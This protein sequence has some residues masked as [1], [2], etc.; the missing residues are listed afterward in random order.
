M[1][2]TSSACIPGQVPNLGTSSRTAGESRPWIIQRAGP[3][4]WPG[5]GTSRQ[6]RPAAVQFAGRGRTWLPG[7]SAPCPG[8]TL[9]D[10]SGQ[11]ERTRTRLSVT[12]TAGQ[13]AQV[14]KRPVNVHAKS[15][16]ILDTPV[17]R[18]GPGVEPARTG[19]GPSPARYG[20]SGQPRRRVGSACYALRLCRSRLAALA[21][22]GL[23]VTGRGSSGPAIR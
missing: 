18:Q 19:R 5:P 14:K 16:F 17:S 2:S 10:A 12:V 11:G 8:V 1:P 7:A 20:R 3:V 15:R 21:V 22:V 23:A 13:R 6:G 9:S 4:R